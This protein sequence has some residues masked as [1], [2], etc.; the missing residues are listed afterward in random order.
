[1]RCCRAALPSDTA[2]VAPVPATVHQPGDKCNAEQANT[3]LL[4]FAQVQ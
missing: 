1:M 2:S 3:A 4:L